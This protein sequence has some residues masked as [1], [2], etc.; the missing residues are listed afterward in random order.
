MAQLETRH[1]DSTP[2]PHIATPMLDGDK[3]H[4]E[5]TGRH[6]KLTTLHRDG[7]NNSRISTVHYPSGDVEVT[8]IKFDADTRLGNK[9]KKARKNDNKAEMSESVLR[10]SQ[11]RSRKIV[12]K[13][14]LTMQCDRLLTLTFKDN[15][16]DLT[17]AWNVVKY[18]HK[19]MK[20]RFKEQYVFIIVP[21]FQKR[22]AVHF[23]LAVKGYYPANTVRHL[24]R[25]AAGKYGG[26]IDIT[27]PRKYNM[28]SWNPKRISR[29]LSKY[30]TKNETVE[31][32]SRRYASTKTLTPPEPTIEW[33][34]YGVPVLQVMNQILESL[35]RKPLNTKWESSKYYEVS[36]IST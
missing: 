16:K 23:H 35:T 29:Y 11:N 34:T 21:E 20:W 19:L 12:Y 9:S 24:W 22:G 31:F 10:K 32:N 28:K 4:F 15:L 6:H 2:K 25:R 3:S 5:L 33:L 26:N 27:N 1:S 8:A 30:I 36:F 17:I 7:G 13:K 18:F 14:A